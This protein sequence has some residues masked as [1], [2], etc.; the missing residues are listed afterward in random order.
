MSKTVD[1]AYQEILTNNS[2]IVIGSKQGKDAEMAHDSGADH[3]QVVGKSI[4]LA[5]PP[6]LDISVWSVRINDHLVKSVDV[7]AGLE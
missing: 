3:R 4:G 6:L 7:L 2:G 5:I 1:L